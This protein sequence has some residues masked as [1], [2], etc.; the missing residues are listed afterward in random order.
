MML[1]HNKGFTLIEILISLAISGIVLASLVK[2][3]SLSTQ[4]TENLEDKETLQRAYFITLGEIKSNGIAPQPKSGKEENSNT[5]LTYAKGNFPFSVDGQIS[6]ENLIY[7][8][9]RGI[10]SIAKNIYYD[11]GDLIKNEIVIPS[12]KYAFNICIHL[13]KKLFPSNNTTT[14]N[15][16]IKLSLVD[17]KD[18]SITRDLIIGPGDLMV[19]L[20]CSNRMSLVAAKSKEIL[21]LTDNLKFAEVNIQ[22][23][24]LHQERLKIQESIARSVS[25]LISSEI[26]YTQLQFFYITTLLFGAV[27]QLWEIYQNFDAKSLPYVSAILTATTTMI[28]ILKD[29]EILGELEKIHSSELLKNIEAQIERSLNDSKLAD[30]HE[31][32]IRRKLS[33][34]VIEYQNTYSEGI[35]K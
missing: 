28:V 22:Q 6:N 1:D 26:S 31:K 5:D 15:Y 19:A 14:P 30:S 11:P 3:V 24:K 8:V 16:T 17:P 25:D 35:L 20:G 18:S 10:L 7:E 21:A 9:D 4:T 2:V 32:N 27:T 13:I 23:K 34:A 29:I 12:N 33:D